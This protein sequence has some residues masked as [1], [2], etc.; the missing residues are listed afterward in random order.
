VTIER[1]R[2]WGEPGA[3]AP[4]GVFVSTDGELR[5][6]VE[7]ALRAGAAPPAVGLL[8]G[9]LCR[10]L[11]GRGDV[12][13]LHS[14]EAMRFPIDVGCA[15]VDGERHW[16]VAHLI[17]RRSWWRGRVVAAM[18]AEFVG[19]QDVAPRSHPN[20][21]FLDVLDGDPSLG[22][23]W[24]ARTRM[25]TGAHVPHP[26][27]AERRVKEFETTLAPRT[28]VWLD[29]SPLGVGRRLRVTVEPDAAVVVV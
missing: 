28:G 19:A 20:D 1:N 3:L 15:E 8:G 12:T 7:A 13:R 29:G 17:A 5:A 26:A 23:R 22:D 2:P 24:K 6:V 11:G 16:F 10:T 25:R 18:N 14:P 21:G 9:D 4:D 27:I